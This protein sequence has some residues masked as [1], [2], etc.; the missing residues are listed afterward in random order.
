MQKELIRSNPSIMMPEPYRDVPGGYDDRFDNEF[1]MKTTDEIDK[2]LPH[3]LDEGLQLGSGAEGS[4]YLA[5][6]C[7]LFCRNINMSL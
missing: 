5:R 1:K 6:W 2:I 3:E 4:V 7:V